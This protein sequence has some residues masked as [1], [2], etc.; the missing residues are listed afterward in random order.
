MTSPSTPLRRA[1]LAMVLVAALLG[2]ALASA[3]AGTT[4][5]TAHQASAPLSGARTFRSPGRVTHLAVHWR[6]SSRARV[7]V[8]LSHDGRRF[9]RPQRVEIDELGAGAPHRGDV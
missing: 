5:V 6:G 7:E 2:A 1:L 3:G 8:Q 9:G 4:Q